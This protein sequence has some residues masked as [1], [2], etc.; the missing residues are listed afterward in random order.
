M[1]NVHDMTAEV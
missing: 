1:Y